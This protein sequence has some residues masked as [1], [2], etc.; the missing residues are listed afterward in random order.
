[1]PASTDTAILIAAYNAAATLDRAIASALA[2]P[3]AIEVC[4]ID[5]ASNDA[6]LSIAQEWARRDP[7]VIVVAQQV[8]GGPAAARNSGIA[9][10]TAPWIGI[11]DAD[12]YLTANRLEQMLEHA[13]DA[14]FIADVLVRLNVGAAQPQAPAWSAAAQTV[15]FID[16]VEGNLG[17][18]DRPLDLGFIK[19]L[20]RRGFLDAHAIRYR[21][22]MRLGEDYELYARSLALGARLLLIPPTGYVSV[23][24][25]GSLS[26]NHSE[27]DLRRL[28]DCDIDLA[29]LRDYTAA[30]RRALTRHYASVD[31]RLQW[32]RLITAVK[33]RNA[34]AA[35]ST[36]HSRDAALYLAARLAEQV[37][38]RSLALVRRPAGEA[39]A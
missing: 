17:R 31:Q 39:T 33:T 12:D 18:A 24:R 34:A 7:R 13:D 38:L 37:W 6:T 14:D 4:V 5:D 26:R 11:L 15:S 10:T 35:L 1:M 8:N 30:E 2:Q 22:E 32:R 28:R 29:N 3:E 21:D 20:M 27:T 16:F 9:A 25:E 36:F 23:E 19:P